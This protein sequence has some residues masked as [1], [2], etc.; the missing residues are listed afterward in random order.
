VVPVLTVEVISTEELGDRSYVVH[1]GQ[2][3]AVIDPQRD[4]DRIQETLTRSGLVC[5]LVLETHVHN[6]YVSG[7]LELARRTG[8][9]YGVAA[10]ESVQFDR[11][12][13]SDGDEI[14]MGS[15]RVRAVATPG[16]TEGHLSYIVEDTG[17]DTAVFTGGSLLYGSVGRTDLVDPSRTEELTRAQYRSVRSLVERL[18]D[19]TPVFPTH[20]FGSFC[21]SGAAVGGEQATVGDERRRNDA[22][23]ID[24]EDRFVETLV[25]GLTAY[26]SYYVRMA[27]INR[28]GPEPVDLSMPEPVDG[29]V[30]VDRIR[31]GEWVVDL[32]THTAFAAEHLR[33]SVGV[34]L[35]PLLTTYLGW[36]L[37]DDAPL[38]LLGESED[39][40]LGAM[41]QL[42]RIG[43]DRPDAAT[44]VPRTLVPGSE[45]GRYPVKTF[46]DLQLAPDAVV[47]DVRLDHERRLG[48]LPG[49]HHVPLHHLPAHMGDLPDGQLW[50]HCAAGYRAAI[51][52]S[53][54]DR[55][56][57]DVVLIYDALPADSLAVPAHSA[58]LAP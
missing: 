6:D 25:A 19:T 1:D 43:I 13:I 50:V 49:S 56:G 9:R 29:A 8:A 53:L 27:P 54:L 20:G 41:R 51:A 38:T 12:G 36:I 5:D 32:R 11:L 52:A 39:Q 28:R 22:L 42:T 26:P 21:S 57:R 45:L 31:A 24:D 33:G 37:P 7:G 58:G 17:G 47:V 18:D 48:F 4:I 3:A 30:L 35:G 14:P 44:G 23:V 46:D 15:L 10:V 34:P 55:S 2:S 16:H 40:V